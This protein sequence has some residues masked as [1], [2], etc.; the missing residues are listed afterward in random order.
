VKRLLALIAA[1]VMIAA[2]FGIRSWLDDRGDGDD[3]DGDSDGEQADG[4]EEVTLWCDPSLAGPCRALEEQFDELNVELR[5][6]GDVSGELTAPD[7]R[8]ADASADGWLVPA[9][10]PA[11]VG[12]DRDRAGQNPVLGEQVGPLARSPLVIA[13]WRDRA[14]AF[15]PNCPDEEIGWRCIGDHAGQDWASLGGQAG[16]GRLEPGF[17]SPQD[18]ATGLLVIGSAS[19]SF[20]DTADFA[21]NDFETDGFR[22]WIRSLEESVP[23]F[24]STVGTP[25]DQML[26]IGPSSYDLVGTT[27]AEVAREVTGTRDEDR[28]RVIYPAPMAT[29]DVVLAPIA[30]RPGTERLA[31]ILQ[32]DEA[33]AALAEAGWRV[34]DTEPIAGVGDQ[35]LPDTNGLPRPGVLQALRNL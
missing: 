14:E 30:G 9:P 22:A 8:G 32:S 7:F 26:T 28:V 16:W 25:L 31:E 34:P 11:M 6:A 2:A 12:E 19:T 20:F 24:P 3:G 15:A 29:A 27:E 35:P 4:G 5:D 23:R 17:E 1:V 18:T 10:Y 13:M 33:S 21:S